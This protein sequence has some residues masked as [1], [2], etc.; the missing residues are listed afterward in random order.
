MIVATSR[1]LRKVVL[2]SERQQVEGFLAGQ[3]AEVGG[4]AEGGN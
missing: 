3:A 2:G 1:S 4:G